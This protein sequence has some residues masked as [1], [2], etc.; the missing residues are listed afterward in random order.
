MVDDVVFN[1]VGDVVVGVGSSVEASVGKG[2]VSL[3]LEAAVELL[4]GTGCGNPANVSV[5]DAILSTGD[6][7]V[8]V[9][10]DS[11]TSP[12]ALLIVCV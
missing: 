5:V 12:S 7:V 1:C 6:T 2:N 8:V 9:V 11:S 3:E 10:D 4:L